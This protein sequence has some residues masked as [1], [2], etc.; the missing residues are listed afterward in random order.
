MAPLGRAEGRGIVLVQARNRHGIDVERVIDTHLVHLERRPVLGNLHR[1]FVVVIPDIDEDDIV[2]EALDMVVVLRIAGVG[3]KVGRDGLLDLIHIV[4]AE[5]I[6]RALEGGLVI[7]GALRALDGP[8]REAAGGAVLRDMDAGGDIAR[9]PPAGADRAAVVLR[10]TRGPVAVEQVVRVSAQ[11]ADVVPVENAD[12]RIQVGILAGEGFVPIQAGRP[13]KGLM[14]RHEDGRGLVHVGKVLPEPLQLFG[15]DVLRV[16]A[17]VFLTGIHPGEVHVVQYDVVDLAEVEGIVVRGKVLGVLEALEVVSGHFHLVVVIPH[18]MEERNIREVAVHGL[19]I[20]GEAVIVGDPVHI[21][22]HV[23]EGKAIDLA[24]RRRHSLVQVP[25]HLFE[26]RQ[27]A[28]AAGQVHIAEDEERIVIPGCRN[29][30]KVNLLGG[31]GIPGE[32]LVVDRKNALD[33]EFI[34]GRIGDEDIFPLLVRVELIMACCVGLY[35]GNTIGDQHVRNALSVAGH[36]AIDIAR[37]RIGGIRN[38]GRIHLAGLISLGRSGRTAHNAAVHIL[39]NDLD[40]VPCEV[41]RGES[42]V[43]RLAERHTLL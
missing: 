11:E 19:E 15:S 25:G 36:G 1:P 14:G 18:R 17:A 22:G 26:L 16:F 12:E 35:D 21:P 28:G 7:M 33:G 5:L 9:P 39:D 2:S 27:V 37:E 4:R 30:F 13:C 24:R 8:D 31:F 6:F 42:D 10:E 41:G 38:L 40:A 34:T 20:V 32:G 23:A 29:K 43:P 3:G